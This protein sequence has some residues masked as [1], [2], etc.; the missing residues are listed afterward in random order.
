M[1]L[2]APVRKEG[3]IHVEN[4]S[5]SRVKVWRRCPR[6]HFYKWVMKLEKKSQPIPLVR[7]K[8]I[9][10]LMEARIEKQPTEPIILKYEKEYAKL[11]SEEQEEFGDI[12]GDIRKIFDGY[13]RKYENDRIKYLPFTVKEKQ[14]DGTTIDVLRHSELPLEFE[15]FPGAKFKGFMDAPAEDTQGNIWVVE[16]KTA[17]KIPDDEVRLSALQAILYV[18]ALPK[19]GY[20]K[21]AGICWDYLRT[22]A[23]TVPEQLKNGGLTKRK[24]ID[25]TYHVYLGEI[26]R[27]GLQQEDYQDILNSLRVKQD[28]FY[29]RVYFPAPSQHVINEVVSDFLESAHEIVEQGRTKKTRALSPFTCKGCSFAS[30]CRAELFDLDAEFIISRDYKLK[31]AKEEL[32]EIQEGSDD[33]DQS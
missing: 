3:D 5:Y 15:L 32:V 7:G 2:V 16:H 17:K 6:E 9:H 10:E 4:I 33:E 25:S 1:E 26:N 11:F 28:N 27:L 19:A 8:I 12:P 18:W 31:G 23:P 13:C 22:K 21:P 14:E 30:L 20:P 29:K 24:N